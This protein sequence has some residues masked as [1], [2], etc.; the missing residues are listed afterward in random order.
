MPDDSHLAWAELTDFSPGLWTTSPYLIPA[1][2]A[3]VMEDCRP[4]I[5]GG[6]RAAMKAT[7]FA[8]T[9]LSS[10]GQVCGIYSRGAIVH[11]S[12][13]TTAS[14]RYIALYDSA[15]YKIKIYRWNETLTSAPTSWTQVI[16]HDAPSSHAKPN[17]VQFDTFVDSAGD[18]HVIWNIAYASTSADGIWSLKFTYQAGGSSPAATQ[19]KGGFFPTALA[20]QDDRIIAGSNATLFWSDSQSVSSWSV[21]NNLPVQASRQ[22]MIITSITPFAPSDLLIGA[23]NAPWTMVQ[24]DITDPVVRSMSDARPTGWTQKVPM[25]T[26]GLAFVGP[27]TSVVLSSNGATFR[28]ISTQIDPATWGHSYSKNGDVGGGECAFLGNFLVAPHGLIYDFRTQAWFTL[29]GLTTSADHFHSTAVTAGDI[30]QLFCATGDDGSDL[31]LWLFDASEN[32]RAAS[33]TWKS[34]PLRNPDGRQI[35]LR[36]VEI[37]ATASDSGST[38]AVTV[39]STTYTRTLTNGVNQHLRYVFAEQAEELDVQIEAASA[40]A[41]V[42]A[43]S[44]EVVRI[45]T[46]PGHLNR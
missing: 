17:P 28:D 9:G 25:T 40:S 27:G 10:T 45:G 34:A 3:S 39:G 31:A 33:Y 42:E 13:P 2:G 37:Y 29:S 4:E 8:T 43:P 22:G 26:Q 24:G 35:R 11:Q 16:A 12:L 18:T 41:S 1:S 7:S 15:D 19:R 6:I 46:R 30:R 38:I 5:G 32:T 14:D 36:S 23:S 21:A 44:I 20:V